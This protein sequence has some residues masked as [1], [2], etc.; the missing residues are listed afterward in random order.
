MQYRVHTCTVGTCTSIGKGWLVA[1]V[2]RWN[3]PPSPL[4]SSTA[5]GGGRNK[6]SI[7]WG[8]LEA[9]WKAPRTFS[10]EHLPRSGGCVR[11]L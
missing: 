4:S 5:I 8:H 2:A 9:F 10:N 11:R 3:V 6:T 7:G 1:L